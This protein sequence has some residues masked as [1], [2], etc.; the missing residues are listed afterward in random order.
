[1][2]EPRPLLSRGVALS[3]SAMTN[4]FEEEAEAFAAAMPLS[5]RAA[6]PSSSA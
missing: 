5:L 2:R 1:M 4:A 3:M 6:T